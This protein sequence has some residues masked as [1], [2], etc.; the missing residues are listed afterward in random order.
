MKTALLLLMLGGADGG[1]VDLSC[2]AENGCLVTSALAWPKPPCP[3]GFWMIS[4]PKGDGGSVEICPHEVAELV[5]WARKQRRAS[6]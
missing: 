6:K 2:T 1:V 5:E 3:G 4:I